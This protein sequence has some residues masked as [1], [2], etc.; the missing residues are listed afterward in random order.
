MICVIADDIT[1]AAEI[2]G[3]GL[4]FGLKVRLVMNTR[5]LPKDC[6]LLVYATDTR[7]LSEE[8]AITQSTKL[9]QILKRSGIK[10]IFKKVDSAL[11]GHLTAE[12]QPF[13]EAGLFKQALLIPQ[14][15]S[16]GRVIKEGMY[17][18]ND[19]PLHETSF[20]DDPEFP[21]ES[22]EVHSFLKGNKHFTIA[23]AIGIQ[24]IEEHTAS[25]TPDTLP[26]GG[27]DFFVCYLKSAYKDFRVH[28]LISLLP[29]INRQPQQILGNKDALIVCGSTM[30]HNLSTYPYMIRKNIPFCN[31]PQEVFEGGSPDKWIS[32]LKELYATSRSLLLMINHP[33]RKGKEFALRLKGV[34]T[35]SVIALLK[36]HFPDELI[37]EGGATAYAI[38]TAMQCC[39]FT[40]KEEISPGVIRLISSDIP[41]LP[42]IMKPGSYEWGDTFI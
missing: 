4:R 12:L 38:L 8:E 20:K 11:R 16:K 35:E 40:V 27:A 26:A 32:E 31:M 42:I 19:T 7:S 34:L 25:L 15:P 5:L 6:D 39:Q 9:V 41:K 23:N 36:E 17:Y 21:A 18:I 37:I 33:P 22:S 14:N 1:G 2:A 3:I 24:E 30:K 13:L 10:N 29:R 28:P